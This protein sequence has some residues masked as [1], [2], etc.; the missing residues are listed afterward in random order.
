MHFVISGEMR[1]G[2]REEARQRGVSMARLHVLAIEEI[3]ERGL[4]G[5]DAEFEA[6]N[7]AFRGEAPKTKKR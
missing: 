2:F 4:K 5:R 1:D 7:A 6:R 3:I